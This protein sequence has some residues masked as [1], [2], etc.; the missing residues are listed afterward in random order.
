MTRQNGRDTKMKKRN[1][2]LGLTIVLM[3]G[4]TA[5][6]AGKVEDEAGGNAITTLNELEN[7]AATGAQTMTEEPTTTE[8]LTTTEEPTTEEPTTAEP[9]TSEASTTTEATTTAEEP[10]TTDFVKEGTGILHDIGGD[11][12]IVIDAGHQR[13]GNYDKEPVGPGSTTLKAK[14]SSGTAGCVTGIAEYEL[15]LTISIMLRDELLE[16]G[17]NVMMIRETHD[18]DI[19][20]SE[21]AM[22]ANNANADAF[23][24]IHANGSENTSKQ[25]AMTI[26][27]TKNN[28]YNASFYEASKKLSA[29]VLDNMVA[30]MG[31]VRDKVW[32]TDTMSGI[33]WCQVP[34]TIVEMGYMSNAEE[35]RLLST[36]DYH[37][38]IVRGIADGIDDYFGR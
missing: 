9:V 10:T 12:L 16:R 23:I 21:R 17:Y 29:Y 18:V 28:P 3:L 2:L 22:I 26:C 37:A 30:A 20:N 24:R 4:M 35:D 38:K 13:K 15:N 1:I 27:Q 32:E 36:S 7:T 5:C 33:N 11:K 34:V 25:G 31:C 14:V 19:S 6:S 8:E